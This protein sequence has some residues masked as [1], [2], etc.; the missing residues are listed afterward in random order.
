MSIIAWTT[1]IIL[2]FIFIF[3]GLALVM[4]FTFFF[5]DG[6]SPAFGVALFLL[7]AVIIAVILP[8]F[9]ASPVIPA[10]IIAGSFFVAFV[11]IIVHFLLP[12][13]DNKDAINAFR[14]LILFSIVSGILIAVFNLAK[15]FIA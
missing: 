5:N 10:T 2:A 8:N 14:P 12:N 15:V 13:V 3:L 6:A 11:G 7:A 1:L 9:T 4:F